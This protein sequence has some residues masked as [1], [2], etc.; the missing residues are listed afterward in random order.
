M[1][2]DRGRW[3]LA[4]YAR[5]HR[6]TDTVTVLDA[7]KRLEKLIKRDRA[8]PDVDRI[9]L[10]LADMAEAIKRTKR[11]IA[12]I[13]TDREDGGAISE[14]SEELDAIVEQTESATQDI[15]SA[16]EQMQ[17]IAWTLREQGFESE[18]CDAIE[19]NA[20]DIY[21]ACGFQDLTGQ[22]TEKVVHVLR[23]LESRITAMMDIWGIEDVDLDGLFAPTDQ[24]PDAHLL[25]GPQRAGSGIDQSEVDDLMSAVPGTV[26]IVDPDSLT[27]DV[28][29]D[30]TPADDTAAARDDSFV[31]DDIAPDEI[32]D[33]VEADDAETVDS[34]EEL[35]ADGA[36]P[37]I[38]PEPQV[39]APPEAPE[40]A[41][42]DI[43][44]DPTDRLSEGEKLA[45]F[46]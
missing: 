5:R 19:G 9:Q 13:R 4:E 25:N 44:T 7:V 2:T 3:F 16:A 39:A 40:P 15:L 31:P 11:E 38:D 46:S 22:R 28:L 21:T 6:A 42:E 17:E 8:V 23:Y 14:A 30:I 35:F 29:D 18:V 45:L 34:D 37:V 26:E 20:T 36:E 43:Q 24:R 27:V 1:E 12:Q 10:D 33:F 41:G 32:V